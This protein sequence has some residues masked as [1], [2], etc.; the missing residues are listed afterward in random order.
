V[1]FGTRAGVSPD[2][3]PVLL[4]RGCDPESLMSC[5]RVRRRSERGE[6]VRV[7]GGEQGALEWSSFCAGI[8]DDAC[9]AHYL[10]ILEAVIVALVWDVRGFGDSGWSATRLQGLRNC[11]RFLGNSPLLLLPPPQGL[12]RLPCRIPSPPSP[13]PCRIPS[14]LTSPLPHP[15][16]TSPPPTHP[17]PPLLLFPCV[18]W[19]EL[20][21]RV[22][23]RPNFFDP[24][25]VHLGVAT[26]V[27][28]F[29]LLKVLVLP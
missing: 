3:V 25:G 10:R 26:F 4:R 6:E 18:V 27:N 16:S 29:R 2:K 24:L 7:E 5:W 11:Y 1:A 13:P 17:T 9:N 28:Q 12:P 22:H 15:I 21:G 20:N 19:F 14:H 8:E 23:T